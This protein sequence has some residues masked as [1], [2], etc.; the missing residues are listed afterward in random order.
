VG[1]QGGGGRDPAHSGQLQIHQYYAR[2]KL[3]VGCQH[4]LAA[5]DLADHLD[6]VVELKG[7]GETAAHDKV[8]V[9]NQEGQCGHGR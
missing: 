5:L 2:L 4:L 9:N 3:T 6:R 1:P 7:G 8:I